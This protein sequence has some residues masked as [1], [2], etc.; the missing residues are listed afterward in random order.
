[1]VNNGNRTE[2]SPIRSVIIRVITGR[3][4][5]QQPTGSHIIRICMEIY[6]KIAKIVKMCEN[7]YLSTYIPH[8]KLCLCCFLTVSC[9]INAILASFDVL[10]FQLLRRSTVL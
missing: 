2:W 9:P 1:M 6:L 10:V 5:S 4:E 3:P 8:E 7:S